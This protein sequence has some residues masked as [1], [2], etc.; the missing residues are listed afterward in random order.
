MILGLLGPFQ[1]IA[2]I[3]LGGLF[4]LGF[5]I[6]KAVGY[7]KGLREKDRLNGEV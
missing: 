3:F 4:I 5:F 6:G 7:K 1:L 2:L